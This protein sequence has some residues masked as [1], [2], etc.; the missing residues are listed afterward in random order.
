MDNPNKSAELLLKIL[1]RSSVQ[2]SVKGDRAVFSLGRKQVELPLYGSPTIISD[3]SA[4]F[5]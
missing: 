1:Q 2:V 4:G 3:R 5:R